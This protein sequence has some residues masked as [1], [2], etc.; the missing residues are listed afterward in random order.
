MNMNILDEFPRQNIDDTAIL[1][2][3]AYSYEGGSKWE[4]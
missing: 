1:L 3:V 2:L 4:K